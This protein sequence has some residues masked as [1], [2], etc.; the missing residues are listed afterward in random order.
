MEQHKIDQTPLSRIRTWIWAILMFGLIGAALGY[1]TSGTNPIRYTSTAKVLISPYSVSVLDYKP[2]TLNLSG[3]QVVIATQMELMNSPQVLDRV[4]MAILDAVA[5]TALADQLP[6]DTVALRNFI[7]ADLS[8]RRVSAAEIIEISFTA[9]DPNLAAL[10]SNE[11]VAQFLL[12][13]RMERASELDR[14]ASALEARVESLARDAEAAENAAS[15]A[16]LAANRSAEIQNSALPAVI[17]NLTQ[18]LA[19]LEDLMDDAENADPEQS[20]A[21]MRR[22]MT[23]SIAQL[24]DIATP[25]DTSAEAQP[26]ETGRLQTLIR[27]AEV[28]SNLHRE[29]LQ[30]LLEVRELGGFLSDDARLVAPAV[31]PTAPSTFQ[32]EVVAALGFIAF[33]LFATL[34]AVV[35]RSLSRP[36]RAWA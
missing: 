31:P 16:R 8:I 17:G 34:I 29:M 25:I 23:E 9:T 6:K 11:V 15:Q 13:Q 12:T 20:L 35:V 18:G 19:A 21:E 7:A 36:G 33:T 2:A 24:Q 4:A 32:P 5:G 26:V 10:V 27:E 28:K 30:R 14:I 22:I 1:A 3:D